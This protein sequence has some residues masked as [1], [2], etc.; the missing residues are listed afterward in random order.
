MKKARTLIIVLTVFILFFAL[1]ANVLAASPNQRVKPPCDPHEPPPP[2]GEPFC[3]DGGY[4][5]KSIIFFPV[6]LDSPPPI[7]DFSK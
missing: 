6:V 2:W 3:P 7:L 1:A 5:S 4:P